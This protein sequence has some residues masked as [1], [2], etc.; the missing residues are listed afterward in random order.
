MKAWFVWADDEWGDFVHGETPGKA[1]SMF[2]NYWVL[3]ASD[4]CS[5]RPIRVPRL[6]DKP[7]TE[8]SINECRDDDD[9]W[10]SP[11]ICRCE[12]CKGAKA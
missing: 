7:L 10:D 5:L 6:D 9:P 3:E 12:I 1:K 4:F 11:I 2:W 8:E